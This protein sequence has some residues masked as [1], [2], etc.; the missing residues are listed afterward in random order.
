M[1]EKLTYRI[2]GAGGHAKVVIDALIASGVRIGGS[3]DSNVSLH[4]K[5]VVPGILVLGD[6][7]RLFADIREEDRV[8]LAIGENRVRMKLAGMLGA[9]YGVAVAPSAVIGG[10]VEI[11]QGAMVLPSAT[12]NCDTRI[13]GHA[14]LN[15]SC[16]VDHDCRIADFVHIAPGSQLGGTVTVGEGT[17]L[18]IG[19]SVTPGVRIGRWSV[20]GAGAVVTKDI[21]DNCTAVGIPARVIKTRPEGWH[22]G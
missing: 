22:L 21:P 18:G 7:K 5:E 9:R 1:T 10:R 15:T 8:I 3:Y 12:V 11:G 2:F 6:E 19:T 4:G 13:G 16:S 17:F 20:I 14:I